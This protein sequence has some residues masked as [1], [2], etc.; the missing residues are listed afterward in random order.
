[1]STVSGEVDIVKWI[2]A[3]HPDSLSIIYDR[4]VGLLI[5]VK[6]YGLA[7]KC[8][9]S[10]L[11]R[12][13]SIAAEFDKAKYSVAKPGY[14][15]RYEAAEKDFTDRV[16][17][18]LVILDKSGEQTLA[19]EIQV[20]MLDIF[21]S[22]AIRDFAIVEP[23]EN[24]IDTQMGEYC[25]KCK[26]ALLVPAMGKTEV[27][28]GR[29]TSR[30]IKKAEEDYRKYTQE[31]RPV[32]LIKLY[33]ENWS[34]TGLS[35]NDPNKI[36]S[37]IFDD[38]KRDSM[39]KGRRI[40]FKNASLSEIRDFL[41][42]R[43]LVTNAEVA[44]AVVTQ[45]QLWMFQNQ[46]ASMADHDAKIKKIKAAALKDLIERKPILAEFKKKGGVIKRQYI[47]QAVDRLIRDRFKGDRQKFNDALQKSG[48]TLPEFRRIKKKEI[49][50][51][52]MRSQ[53]SDKRILINSRSTLPRQ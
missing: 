33:A 15:A 20:A 13:S 30:E 52:A 31:R 40:P 25:L 11:S 50:V 47:D 51:G 53:H 18:L 26:V 34:L 6:D 4:V 38:K 7:R 42:K 14:K 24:F 45:T 32:M 22:P 3:V 43:K 10:P 5:E 19:R 39:K 48:L 35:F 28:F 36:R 27:L 8:L 1:M 37:F 9:G 49:I 2:S 41:Q 12:V 44:E 16:L 23:K 46:K 21:E 29:A 17:K